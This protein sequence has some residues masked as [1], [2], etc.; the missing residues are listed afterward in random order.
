MAT[1]IVGAT[2]ASAAEAGARAGASTA[3]AAVSIVLDRASV[4][5]SIGQR[6]T[7]TSTIRNG[8]TEVLQQPVAHL[9]V[10]GLDPD[11]YVDPE[12]WSSQRTVYLGAI[13]PGGTATVSWNVQAVTSGRVMLYV[14]V[15]RQHQGDQVAVSPAL[16]AQVTARRTINAGGVLPVAITVPVVMAGLLAA[17]RVRQRR[18]R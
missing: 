15:V 14:A 10:L 1:M 5:T 9:N 2:V 12:D 17:T 16:R 3:P 11:V 4:S 13:A 18:R 7:F 8:G 6:F